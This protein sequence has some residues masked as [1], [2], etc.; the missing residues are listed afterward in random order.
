MPRARRPSVSFWV[1]CQVGLP[2]ITRDR[3]AIAFC[4]FA[5]RI[6]PRPFL[7]S[8]REIWISVSHPSG[9]LPLLHLEKMSAQLRKF[10]AVLTNFSIQRHAWPWLLVPSTL[11]PLVNAFGHSKLRIF[12]PIPN[13]LR[14]TIVFPAP[15]A[16]H[17]GAWL[18]CLW[19]ERRGYVAV[20][21]AQRRPVL[22][23]LKT[24]KR[25]LDHFLIVR[26]PP[27]RVTIPSIA[28]ESRP[29]TTSLYGQCRVALN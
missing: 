11:K 25:P 15:A 12:R 2:A 9:S 8:S 3:F 19:G 20:D 5:G 16:R 24:L 13:T 4:T 26:R 29:S 6:A 28:D 22:G 14:E 7:F 23:V 17:R 1:A 10:A 21:N 18:S 27:T